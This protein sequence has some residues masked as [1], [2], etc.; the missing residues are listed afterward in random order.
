MLFPNSLPFQTNSFHVGPFPPCYATN[1]S[2]IEPTSH[3]V[4]TEEP[5]SLASGDNLASL[6]LQH[7][8]S[9]FLTFVTYQ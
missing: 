4:G 9:F 7:L 1:H 3:L 5:L 6:S 8:L 2:L